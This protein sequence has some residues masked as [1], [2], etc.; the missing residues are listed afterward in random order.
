MRARLTVLFI[1]V[2][3]L[4]LVG[5]GAVFAY[6]DHPE[7]R[8]A[9]AQEP[10]PD[11]DSVDA[12]RGNLQ[13]ASLPLAVLGAGVGQLTDGSRQLDDG[14]HLLADG[15]AQAHAGGRQLADG[16]G[17]LEGGVTQLGDGA[18]Q[19]SAGVDELVERLTGFGAM[20]G[21]VSAQL[22][23]VADGLALAAD[24]V[25]QAAAGELRALVGTLNSEGLGPDTLDQLGQL[26]DGARQLSYELTA[27]DAEF[28]A[29]M[30][31]AADGSRQ[32]RDGLM[33]LDDGGRQLVDGTG[34]L[35]GGVAPVG[36]VVQG[37]SD[38]VKEATGALPSQ[39]DSAQAATPEVD[40]ATR[41]WWPYALVAVGAGLLGLAALGNLRPAAASGHRAR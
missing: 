7:P 19:I 12:V 8:V 22:S 39:A 13:Q 2:A 3:G 11:D 36:N 41:Q 10:D 32:L 38:N 27:P 18:T 26:R 15:L 14:A 4:V 33:Q 5:S 23:D 1:A 6:T 20:Q 37:I 29:G 25:S 30:A 28:V 24:P 35:A 40:V 34:Q 21:S 9:V 16:L 31:Q 17:Q